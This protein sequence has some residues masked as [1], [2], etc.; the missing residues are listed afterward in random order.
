MDRLSYG[1]YGLL[2]LV[3]L[4][5][6]AITFNLVPYY[7]ILTIVY[8]FSRSKFEEPIHAYGL[9]ICYVCTISFYTLIFV[10]IKL[11]N[12]VIDEKITFILLV[13]LVLLSTFA[14]STLP[15]KMENLGKVFF[16]YKKHDESKY[17]K[18]IDF[19]KF[20]G[21]NP[22]LIETEERLKNYDM[23]IYLLYKR[24]FRENRTFREISEEFDIDNPRIVESLDKAYFYMIGALGI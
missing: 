23:Q 4:L 13:C 22:L 20:N 3:S 19:I 17:N 5:I 14:T 16:G 8:L 6:I 1:Q 7:I 2:V 18:L 21:I 11:C 10:T 15:N 12:L 24:K 9:D